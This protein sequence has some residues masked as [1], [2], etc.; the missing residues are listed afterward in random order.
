M[1]GFG[2]V[3]KAYEGL[4]GDFDEEFDYLNLRSLQSALEIQNRWIWY[5]NL[6]KRTAIFPY[7]QK[8]TAPD[9]D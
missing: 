1:D 8:T 7:R 6:L 4:D 3:G 2:G 5:E 9:Q